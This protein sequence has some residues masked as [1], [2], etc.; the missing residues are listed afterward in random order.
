MLAQ[1]VG[2]CGTQ[3]GGVVAVL[4]GS[5]GGVELA[6]VEYAQWLLSDNEMGR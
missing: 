5:A 2:E 6:R 4:V 1:Q 3:L